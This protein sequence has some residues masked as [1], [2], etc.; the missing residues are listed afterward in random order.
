MKIKRE[1]KKFLKKLGNGENIQEILDKHID[2]INKAVTKN[3]EL[4]KFCKE[5]NNDIKQCIQKVRNI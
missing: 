2:K 3:E 5:L 1:Y 4:D